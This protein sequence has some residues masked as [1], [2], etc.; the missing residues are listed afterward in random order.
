MTT[1]PIANSADWHARGKD[2]DA[3]DRQLGALVNQTAL[4]GCELHCVAG[5]IFDEPNIAD[6]RA[7]TGAIVEIVTKH[8]ANAPFRWLFIPGNHDVSGAGSVD[9]LTC[10][11]QFKNVTVMR[12]AGVYSDHPARHIFSNIVCL[13]WDWSG[14]TTP[15]QAIRSIERH[16]A[17]GK[18]DI[19]LAH[20]QRIGSRMSGRKVCEGG[21]WAISDAE[22]D[23]F[24]F[25]HLALGDFHHRHNGYVGALRQLNHGE[26]GNPAG[27]ELWYPDTN[28]TKWIELN[29]APRYRT[30]KSFSKDDIWVQGENEILRVQT[31]GWVPSQSEVIAAEQAAP[32][33]SFRVEPILEREERIQ[34]AEVPQGAA[35]DPAALINLWASTQTP[36]IEPMRIQRMMSALKEIAA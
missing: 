10:L 12:E 9:A 35:S 2:L 36:P 29:E 4:A 6:S 34:R 30:V 5:D 28:E 15:A 13:P 14:K 32:P 24:K 16:H 18:P 8:V 21:S 7:S 31:I 17:N 33:N 20:V 26:E 22:L 27:F 11:D 23:A 3:L 1:P 19:L 25:D